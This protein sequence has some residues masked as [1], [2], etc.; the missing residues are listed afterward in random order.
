MSAISLKKTSLRTTQLAYGIRAFE[1]GNYGT[2]S[3]R[4]SDRLAPDGIGHRYSY[5]LA[6]VHN[7]SGRFPGVKEWHVAIRALEGSNWLENKGILKVRILNKE[8]AE[9]INRV[10]A[11][12][13]KESIR[14]YEKFSKEVRQ[15]QYEYRNAP[16]LLAG[17]D[18]IFDEDMNNQEK[19]AFVRDSVKDTL[20]RSSA[21]VDLACQSSKED[22]TDSEDLDEAIYDA[23]CNNPSFDTL[24]FDADRAIAG[25][26]VILL[27]S[28]RL[29]ES[30]RGHSKA[31]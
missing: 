22:F 30:L 15:R 7:R 24:G 31:A 1:V 19:I 20:L 29:W 10:L 27:G 13:L 3:L 17:I 6:G 11:P 4:I 16:T 26:K 28:G 9:K 5:L 21:M 14:S 12:I 25:V 23:L 8:A 2:V 18:D